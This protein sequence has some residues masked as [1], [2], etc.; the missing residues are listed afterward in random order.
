MKKLFFTLAVTLF[1]ISSIYSQS[2]QLRNS[3][4]WT[5][6]GI[7]YTNCYFIKSYD[8]PSVPDLESKIN[9]WND[10][11]VLENE[12]YIKVFRKAFLK[13]P[14]EGEQKKADNG[15]RKLIHKV[16]HRKFFF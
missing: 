15:N 9:A 14:K 11:I 6:L 16:F 3:T 2:D 13:K 1:T 8:F 12:K 5:W 10:L 7:D 4:D